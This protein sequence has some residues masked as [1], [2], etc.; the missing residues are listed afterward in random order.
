M[1][2]GHGENRILC[3]ACEKGHLAEKVVKHDVGALV[4][5]SSVMVENLPALVCSNCGAVTVR[6]N[7]LDAVTYLLA[8]LILKRSVLD[9]I[10]VRYLRGLLGDTQEELAKSLDVDRATVNR[11]EN[12]TTPIT[13]TQ[14]Y[15]IRTHAFFRL[16][17]KSPAVDAASGAFVYREG[18]NPRAALVR[19]PMPHSKRTGYQLDA[20]AFAA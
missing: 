20:A 11:W 6:G 19:K 12:S 1:T 7:T 5:M 16:R 14:A 13:G 3:S 10:E 2:T 18:P 4:G 17:D 15:A 8:A 9:A